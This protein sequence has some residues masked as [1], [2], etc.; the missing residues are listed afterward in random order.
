[1]LTF[2]MI[3]ATSFPSLRI[4]HIERQFSVVRRKITPPPDGRKIA[5]GDAAVRSDRVARRSLF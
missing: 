2:R 3:R 5:F 1:M 4:G